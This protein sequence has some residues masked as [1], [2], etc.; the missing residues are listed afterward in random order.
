MHDC[1]DNTEN[2]DGLDPAEQTRYARHLILPLF[3][4]TGQQRLKNARVLFVG[5][6]GLGCAPALYL[7]AAGVG[8]IG[9]ADD[10]V[11]AESNL[12]RQVLYTTADIGRPKVEAA[13]ERLLALNPHIK[14]LTHPHR[15]TA[16]NALEVMRAYD[17]II[18]GTDNIPARYLINDAA[19]FL[20]KPWVYAGVHQFEGQCCVFAPDGPCYRCFFRDP[21][22]PEDMPSCAEAGVIGVVPG[23]MGLMQ[24]NEVI[25]LLSGIGE[26]LT[27]RLLLYDALETRL[28]EV[29]I[30]PDPACPLCGASP[31][32]TKLAE[33]AWT[34]TAD[35]SVPE[36]SVKEFKVIY[37]SGQPIFLL[38]VREESEHRVARIER[39]C[40]IP[41][42]RL[43]EQLEQ[44][45]RDKPVYCFC[46]LG[47]RSAKAVR[48]LRENGF[49]VVIS[50]TGGIRAWS[51][52][53]DPDV[54]V[55]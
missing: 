33:T 4:E 10:D 39:A 43:A 48:L 8:T 41:L 52:Q 46:K 27:G 5:A 53:I 51:E 44:I 47:G 35:D 20:K 9:L 28:R 38:D 21:P 11:V 19:F 24:A 45:P 13:R 22:R 26:P 1:P 25:K 2:T 29:R 42:G 23:Q 55:Y 34:C 12:Q 54:P 16:A 50:L 18:D 40:L 6:G 31:S 30:K 14:V 17:V 7:A 3:G 15:L 49:D 32:I 36:V 37:D